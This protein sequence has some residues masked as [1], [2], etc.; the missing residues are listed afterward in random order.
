MTDRKNLYRCLSNA[1]WGYLL[2]HFD[3][4]LGTVSILPAFAGYLLL[5]SAISGL[6]EERRDLVLL[7]PL[8][9]LLAVWNGLE[10]LLSWAGAD[11]S[12]LF[13]PLDIVVT[14]TGL[15]FHFQFLTDMAALAEKLQ[16]PDSELDRQIRKRRTL[17]MVL[18]TLIA[19]ISYLPLPT[20]ESRSWIILCLGIVGCIVAFLVMFALFRLRRCVPREE[21]SFPK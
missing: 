13:P 17:Y 21:V 9:I 5:F 2:L 18:T 11:P 4:N 20:E 16:K 7:R 15:Y 8:C 10:W 6:S 19:V 3:I 14:V 1:A 12:G